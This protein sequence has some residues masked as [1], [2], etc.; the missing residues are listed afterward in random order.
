MCNYEAAWDVTYLKANTYNVAMNDIV[1]YHSNI[2]INKVFN[3][4]VL[5]QLKILKPISKFLVD[6]Y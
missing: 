1:I 3:F 2:N 4:S 6:R 5:V